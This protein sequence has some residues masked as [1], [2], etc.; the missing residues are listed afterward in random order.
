MKKSISFVV[1]VLVG[2]FGFSQIITQD[3][4]V[5]PVIEVHGT[6]KKEIVP[7]E[8][9]IHI[10]IKERNEGRNQVTVEEQE[11][12]LKQ[13][14]Q[15]LGI[16]LDNLFLSDA[17]ANYT[18]VSWF[19]KGVISETFYVLKVTNADKVSRVFEM[20]HSIH[21]NDARVSHVSHSDIEMLEQEVRIEAIKSAKAKADYLLE[22]IGEKTGKALNVR[23]N[24]NVRPYPQRNV[25]YAQYSAKQ[26]PENQPLEYKKITISS[27]IYVQF[28]IEE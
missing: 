18:S 3:N 25:M 15:K 4:K 17:Q 21:I 9:F 26:E 10:A 13:K 22:A 7:N 19:R 12:K 5:L 1:L 6:A 24:D 14:V 11:K 20:L 23:E 2:Y 27:S 16:S 8:I 28:R